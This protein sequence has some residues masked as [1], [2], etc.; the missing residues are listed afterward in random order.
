MESV[1]K[2]IETQ[3]A[4]TSSSK[5]KSIVY[6]GVDGV[7]TTFSIIAAS[8]GAS[9]DYK[10]IIMLA[11]SNL[12]ADASSMG[13]GD[14]V[15]S[16]LEKQYIDSER[17]KE[18]YEYHC[19]L[20]DEINELICIYESKGLSEEDAIVITNIFSKNEELFIQ[21][22]MVLELELDP[23]IT[24]KREIIVNS[25]H[26][27]LSFIFFGAFP[28][29]VYIYAYTN[30]LNYKYTFITSSI[31]SGLTL[32]GVGG[33]SAKISKQNIFKNGFATMTNGIIS[34]SIAYLIGYCFDKWL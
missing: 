14:Y 16:N 22:M 18:T 27:F 28:I 34:G 15:S 10:V 19:N 20:D 8:Y 17:S 23:Y 9:L 13:I 1:I 32:F 2:H 12:F 21:Q 33:I 6:G 25:I 29:Y 5:I 7:I 24:T 31:L 26:T 11:L 4:N 30:D 3:H